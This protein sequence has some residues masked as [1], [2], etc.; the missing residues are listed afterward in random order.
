MPVFACADLE[1]PT[2]GTLDDDV[3]RHVCL[4]IPIERHMREVRGWLFQKK[5]ENSLKR[6]ALKLLNTIGKNMEKAQHDGQV[7]GINGLT[8]Q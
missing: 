2:L 1:D 7:P 4:G 8:I 6:K 3:G 5:I